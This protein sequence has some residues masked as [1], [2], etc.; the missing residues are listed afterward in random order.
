MA[1]TDKKTGFRIQGADGVRALA[2]LCVFWHHTATHLDPG[3]RLWSELILSQG[4]DA[5]AVFF[6]LSGM[7]LTL[8][9][10]QEALG[11]RP[12]PPLRNYLVAR[13][14]RIIPAYYVCLFITWAL[15]PV[16]A[17]RL[18]RIGAGLTCTNWTHW[19]TFFPAPHNTA[20]WS[21]GVEVAFYLLLPLWAWGLM[22]SGGR[23]WAVLYW[24]TTQ[25]FIAVVQIFFLSKLRV[26]AT[27]A[28]STDPDQ[29]GA[30]EFM[31]YRNPIGL[32]SH[33]LFG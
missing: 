12:A 16:G 19:K 22:R 3:K 30:L 26:D 32:F 1:S 29:F 23:K 7:L 31:D 8:P 18:W 4:R 20:L 9:F 2:C 14:G 6:V 15:F 28:H 13:L 27:M 21:I 33:F 11:T 17:D 24:I 25:L 10:W 5:V